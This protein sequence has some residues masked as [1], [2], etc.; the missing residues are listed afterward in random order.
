MTATEADLRERV[1]RLEILLGAGGG[2][3]DTG[4]LDLGT[5][6]TYGT[7]WTVYASDFHRPMCRRLANGLVLFRGL[8][9]KSAALT[10]A[11][12]TMFLMPVGWRIVAPG[13]N[14]AAT[15]VEI[16]STVSAAGHTDVRVYNTGQVNLVSGG[17]V[18]FVS[19]AGLMYMSTRGAS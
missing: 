16:L 13:Y 5:V 11:E 7:N 9:A 18:V 10:G 12:E 6:A 8:V 2:A 3:Y 4:W 14:L 19:L 15:T 1:E 17:S